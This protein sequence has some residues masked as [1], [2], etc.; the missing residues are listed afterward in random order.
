MIYKTMPILIVDDEEEIR[1]SLKDMLVLAGYKV[2]TA[3]NG[4][5]A[6]NYIRGKKV[7]MMLIDLSMPVMDGETLIEQL[8]KEHD[9]PPALVIT[10]MAPWRALKLIEY[11]VG[12]LRKP[13]NGELLLDTVKTILGKEDKDGHAVT[14]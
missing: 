12:Y 8:K 3:S 9:M 1:S 5:E 10:A 4:E 2:V 11:G 7:H 13:I 14:C 6:L